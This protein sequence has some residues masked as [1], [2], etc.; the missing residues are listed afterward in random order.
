MLCFRVHCVHCFF[1]SEFWYCLSHFQNKKV[2][3]SFAGE[4]S[5]KDGVLM[6]LNMLDVLQKELTELKA[7]NENNERE[8]HVLE[9]NI[10]KIRT[11]HQEEIKKVERKFERKIEKIREEC[12]EKIRS[13]SA[14]TTPTITTTTN[15]PHSKS[16][17]GR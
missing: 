12:E 13:C 6:L 5:Q 15:V 11:N 16:T 7:K 1:R 9:E 17:N 10:R 3:K 2:T 14:P 8:K 4:N